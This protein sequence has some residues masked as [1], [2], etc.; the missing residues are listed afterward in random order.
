MSLGKFGINRQ[1]I[2]QGGGRGTGH[3]RG[4]WIG[5][6]MMG[7][8]GSGNILTSLTTIRPPAIEENADVKTAAV[9]TER[10][11]NLFMRKL[12]VLTANDT[13]EW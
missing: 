6:S 10:R 5:C 13:P 7:G 1:Q 8:L 4:G 11:S 12:D 9:S 2:K 3:G